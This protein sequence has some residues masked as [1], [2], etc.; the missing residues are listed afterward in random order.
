MPTWYAQSSNSNIAA[1]NMWNSATDGSGDILNWAEMETNGAIHT[2]VANGKTNIAITASFTC[3][4]LSTAGNGGGFICSSNNVTITT[5]SIT[6]GTTVCLA[7]A[8]P[9]GSS[10]NIAVT[11]ITG[12]GSANA[13][14]IRT[15]SSGTLNIALA[16]TCKGGTADY[17][18]G[19]RNNS[20]TT[21]NITG[22]NIEPNGH[23]TSGVSNTYNGVMTLNACNLIN[24][25]FGAAVTGRVIYNPGASNYIRYPKPSS[26]TQDFPLQLPADKIKLGEVSGTLTG[27]YAGSGGGVG[28][29][30]LSPVTSG[31]TPIY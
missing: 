12:G 5:G 6:A 27:T 3:A 21:I 14:G 20:N 22:G 9:A 28:P 23:Y 15:G 30:I 31:A 11:D 19:V 2:L 16:G 29:S 17:V 10:I 18:Y 26:G 24:T 13:D 4:A 1:A 7:P 25:L 8:P